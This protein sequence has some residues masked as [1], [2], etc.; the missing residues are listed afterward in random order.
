MSA[1]I[2]GNLN[3]IFTLENNNGDK[4][5]VFIPYIS[6]E[7]FD[8]ISPVLGEIFTL[9]QNGFNPDVF[10]V[11]YKQTLELIFKKLK[12][13]SDDDFK[14]QTEAFLERALL[15]AQVLL[16][17]GEVLNYNE[18]LENDLFDDFCKNTARSYLLFISALYRYLTPTK[19]KSSIGHLLTSQSLSEWLDLHKKSSKEQNIQSKKKYA[20]YKKETNHQVEISFQ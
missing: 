15:G 18:A 4:H 5:Q 8:K 14:L 16:S 13:I 10:A 7:H 19:K 9:L 17:N 3:F 6:K 20:Q 1:K 12:T 11:D 2:D